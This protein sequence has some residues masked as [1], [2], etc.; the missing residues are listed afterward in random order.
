V[1]YPAER[2]LH[3][4]FEAQVE[5]TPERVAVCH[6][7][8]SLT[9]RE[10]NT[11]ANRLAH[12]LLELGV[13]PEDR[14]G[15]CAERSLEMLLAVLGV[16][17]AGGAY[18]PLDP[19]HPRERLDYVLRDA[20]AA[21]LLIQEN[22]AER[23]LDL[24]ASVERV[25]LLDRDWEEISRCT[26]ENPSTLPL[27][28]GR[29]AYVIYTSGSTGQPKGVQIPHR[30]LVNFLA[31]MGQ[32]PG[33]AE[34]DALL[35]VTTLSFDIAGLELLLPLLTGA[36]VIVAPVEVVGDG[37]ALARL[38]KDS[39]ATVM[40]A[41]PAT[42]RLL[43]ESG[44]QGDPGLRV[45]CGGEALPRDLAER[46]LD[47][48]G[49][50]WNLYGPTETTIWSTADL[51]RHG[52]G[53]VPLGG[54]IANT[55]IHLLDGGGQ[56][57]PIGVPGELFIGG[58]GVARG[59]LGRPALTAERFVPDPFLTEPGARMYR[60]GDLVRRRAD[61][62]LEFLGRTDFQV[63]IRGFRIEP[64][65]IEAQLGRLTGVREAIVLARGD[66]PGDQ[67]LVAYTTLDSAAGEAPSVAQMRN[68][69]R[70]RL[71]AYMVPAGLVVLDR[72]PVTP[73]GKV[74]RKALLRIDDRHRKTGVDSRVPQ[75][76]AELTIASILQE[77]LKIDQVGVDHNFFD[78]GG[79]SLLLVQVNGRLQE[80]F[81][82][83]ILLV[84]IFNNPTVRALA[85]HLEGDLAGAPAA[86]PSGDRAKQLRQGRD[87]LRRR[88]QQQKG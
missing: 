83:E 45:F 53:P 4:L 24:L 88:F 63:K 10:L 69:L 35:A 68:F 23:M 26:G 13:G 55:Q 87:R 48:V 28:A 56:P 37:A 42:W 34:D 39:G 2:C 5:R 46:L 52:E 50:L 81:G 57:V 1:P 59:Y 60:T 71:P 32:Q 49:S 66:T 22:V 33:L 86:A 31:S 9:Y 47:K 15:I 18:V 54:P 20:G 61:G 82:R 40:Q 76:E 80:R 64:G 36:R 27:P 79:N 38:L 11:A 16:L 75:T 65:E 67:R 25:I 85:A 51:V 58:D 77:V 14:V 6:G 7:G 30:A 43:L 74:D 17:K 62:A 8:R 78:L 84:E 21:V 3:E 72:L 41:T 29:L 44:W 12:H 73:N 70:E 19:I